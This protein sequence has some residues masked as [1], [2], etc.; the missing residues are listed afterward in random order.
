LFFGGLAALQPERATAAATDLSIEMTRESGFFLLGQLGREYTIQVR[1]IGVAATDGGEVTVQADLPAGML[2]SS[3]SGSGWSCNNL[4]KTCVR[5][6]SLAAGASYSPIRL[7]VGIA[8]SSPSLVA[9]AAL[10]WSGDTNEANNAT[11]N[12]VEVYEPFSPNGN[13]A[14]AKSAS[15]IVDADELPLEDPV[16]PSKLTYI[17]WPSSEPPDPSN[18]GWRTFVDGETISLSGEDGD[19]YLHVRAGDAG[20]NFVTVTTER[21]RLDNTGPA[22]TPH[23]YAGDL[24]PYTPAYW[25]HESVTVDLEASDGDG[26]GVASLEFTLNGGA[27]WRPIDEFLLSASGIYAAFFRGTDLLG[28]VTQTTAYDIYIDKEPPT[29]SA[30]LRTMG[31]DPYE[32]DTWEN[33]SVVIAFSATETTTGPALLDYSTDGTTFTP[34]DGT[35][36]FAADGVRDVVLRARDLAGNEATETHRVKIDKTAPTVSYTLRKANGQP[37]VPGTKTNQA[38]SFQTLESNDE[39]SGVDYVQYSLNGG[40]SWLPIG[41][42]EAIHANGNFDLRIRAYDRAGNVYDTA[43]TPV[44]VEILTP[45]IQLQPV[46]TDPTNAGVH[47]SATFSDVAEGPLVSKWAQGDRSAAYFAEE[48]TDFTGT[49]FATD[50]G[51]YTVYVRDAAGNE[52]VETILIESVVRDAPVLTLS[53]SPEAPTN[54]SVTVT[55]ADTVYGTEVGNELNALKWAEGPVTEASYFAADGIAIDG[56]KSF[57]VSSNGV[58][59]VYAEDIAGNKTLAYATVTNINEETPSISVEVDP[60][61]PTNGAVIVTVTASVYGAAN[62]LEW[63]RWSS[64]G[65]TSEPQDVSFEEVEGPEG[66]RSYRAEVPV[67]VNGSYRIVVRDEAGN[68]KAITVGIAH[69]FKSPPSIQLAVSPA[70]GAR[71]IAELEA[72]GA[73]NSIHRAKWVRGQWDASDFDRLEGVEA[74]P[75]SFAFVADRNGWYTVFAEDAAGN[76]GAASVEVTTVPTPKLEFALAE[77]DEVALTFDRPLEGSASLRASDFEVR[78]VEAT[79]ASAH[80]DE[81]D[82]RVVR[83]KLNYVGEAPEWDENEA[84]VSLEAGAVRAAIGTLNDA[85][86]GYYLISPPAAARLANAIDPIG[87]GIGIAEL[88]AFWREAIDFDANKDGKTDRTDVGYLL[89]FVTP[90]SVTAG[91]LQ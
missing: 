60:G 70:D 88:V 35:I 57:V 81:R 86:S 56:T 40:A 7:R 58:Y 32:D 53:I 46:S 10:T 31:G 15:V 34:S 68:E 89:R 44:E 4:A 22:L 5:S 42:F 16:D 13:E 8:L 26:S 24:I 82:A 37:Y 90:V 50:N 67:H 72:I 36:E 38:V 25:V 19:W 27:T 52:A 33:E 6:D 79:I 69:I 74:P 18:E 55:V 61:T 78:G 62:H 9:S 47:V 84:S 45:A 85:V 28:N 87:D 64:D 63:I 12:T 91:T 14:W 80:V 11:N 77:G 49:F 75:D 76:R 21:F 3:M 73:T 39:A 65:D 59:T 83:L 2:L 43:S 71:I 20:G 29:L 17:W 41:S 54:G 30:T 1:N 48:G 51:T 23:L 66:M